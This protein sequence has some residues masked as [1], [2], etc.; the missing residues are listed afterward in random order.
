MGIGNAKSG[1][2]L[3]H[4]TD[5]NNLDS[6]FEKG[7]LPRKYILDN[8]FKFSDVADPNIIVKRKELGLDSYTP[9]HFHPYSAFDVAVKNS[10]NAKRMVYI[11]VNRE[12]AR[13]NG[14]LILP[15]HPLSGTTFKLY[16]YDEGLEKIDWDTM[17]A[18]GRE[19]SY[20]KEVK[21]AE[22]LTDKIIPVDSFACL[23]VASNEIKNEVESKLRTYNIM[24]PPPY[25]NVQSVWF[26]NYGV[27]L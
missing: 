17:T 10:G 2:L 26:D 4:L 6:I 1:M 9:F 15:R 3:Y 16:Q 5:I 18:T 23:Y 24:C 25:V 8:N 20:A 12:T 13:K 19:D 21:M 7:L 27:V 14:F 22:C 11:C